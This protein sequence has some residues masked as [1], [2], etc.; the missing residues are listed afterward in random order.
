MKQ[1]GLLT[2][3]NVFVILIAHKMFKPTEGKS[4]MNR[5]RIIA[6]L[7][8]AIA[9]MSV[10]TINTQ[11][12]DAFGRFLKNKMENKATT[13]A[14]KTNT[15]TP[16]A[17]SSNVK[18][19]ELAKKNGDPVKFTN[20]RYHYTFTYPDNWQLDDDDPK[21]STINVIDINGKMGNFIAS[22]T[23]MSDNFPVD[24][25]F[26]ALIQKAEQRKKHGE[27]EDFYVKKI[28]AKVN[29]KD[30]DVVKG[31]VII[32]SDLDP[33][34]KRMQWEAYGGGNYYNFTTS[35]NVANFPEYK[36]KFKEMIDSLE[37]NFN[38]N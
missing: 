33:S 17:D 23:W 18:D 8:F 4:S 38:A 10:I 19:P 1:K 11:Q 27:L 12:A 2:K 35:T 32:E 16:A 24:P 25:A 21:K 14:T 30:V 34:M 28:T 3:V 5:R 6:M 13:E 15:D 31:V 22:S 26:N 36:D 20:E 7:A 37:F 29:G 9:M